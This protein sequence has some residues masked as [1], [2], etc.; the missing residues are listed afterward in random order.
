MVH[1]GFWPAHGDGH[2]RDQGGLPVIA[3]GGGVHHID[4]HGRFFFGHAVELDAQLGAG[5]AEDVDAWV[6]DLYGD[7]Y[8]VDAFI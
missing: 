8:V 5:G 1:L 6:H 2:G 7:I 3:E 4:A